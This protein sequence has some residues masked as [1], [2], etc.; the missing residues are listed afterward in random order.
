[1][2]DLQQVLRSGLRVVLVNP[3]HPGNV[4]ATARAMKNSGLRQ[5][6]V[7]SPLQF[8]MERARWMA[9]GGRDVLDQARFVST[10]AEAVSD[11]QFAIG[12]TAR[13]R[14][15]DWPVLEPEEL[16]EKTM[17]TDGPIAILFGREDMGLDNDA[18]LQ[19]Q[20]LLKIPTDGE[21]SLNLSQAVL[22]VCQAVFR[23]AVALGWEP[24]EEARQGPRSAG[25]ERPGKPK[26]TQPDPV[27]T[28]DAQSLLL[29][30]AMRLLE[31]TTYMVGQNDEQ[32]RVTLG[33][34]L[35]RAAP[36]EKEVSILR[37]MFKKTAWSLENPS[38]GD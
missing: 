36:T 21:P 32:V 23:K 1:M 25:R 6:V 9:G 2:A 33:N 19:C 3:I 34:L 35:Q 20:A 17:S 13:S 18:L 14:R 24:E 26:T 11:C 31:Q 4:G 38:K 15:W 8:D 7:V 37:G 22:L 27:A 5:L 12:C 16:A 30:E 10:V 28:L 29:T